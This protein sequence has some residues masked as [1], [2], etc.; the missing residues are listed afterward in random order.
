MSKVLQNIYTALFLFALIIINYLPIDG[1]FPAYIK[2]NFLSPCVFFLSIFPQ[3]RPSLSMLIILGLFEDLLSNSIIGLTPLVYVIT[4]L[5]A[6]SNS[7]ALAQQRFVIV[8]LSL[9]IV[10]ILNTMIKAYF[11]KIY[12]DVGGIYLQVF[13]S[14]YFSA[15]LYPLIHYLLSKNIK[16]F[17]VKS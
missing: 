7:K 11:Y 1:I 10:L 2:P 9:C 8:W 12:Y 5:I 17:G 3:A 14:L 6:S 15:L 13:I 16:Y 4:Q